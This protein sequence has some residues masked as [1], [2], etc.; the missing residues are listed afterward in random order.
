M[1]MLRQARTVT[2][3]PERSNESAPTRIRANRRREELQYSQ[4]DA[5]RQ[6]H[7]RRVSGLGILWW[8]LSHCSQAIYAGVRGK[9]GSVLLQ[10][11]Q[12]QC[13][14]CVDAVICCVAMTLRLL[15]EASKTR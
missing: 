4:R 6:A 2:D 8:F 11:E 13:K 7:S 1:E 10:C 3:R 15:F 5:Q 14:C 12:T 9:S